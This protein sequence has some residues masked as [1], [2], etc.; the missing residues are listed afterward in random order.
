[1]L[2]DYIHEWKASHNN[3]NDEAKIRDFIKSLCFDKMI[4]IDYSKDFVDDYF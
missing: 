1:M 4:N 2:Y 3:F